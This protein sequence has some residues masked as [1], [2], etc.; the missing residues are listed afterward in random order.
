MFMSTLS[1]G[2]IRYQKGKLNITKRQKISFL[3]RWVLLTGL[4]KLKDIQIL[5]QNRSGYGLPR[6]PAP[7][8]QDCL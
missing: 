6:N 8:I 4:W 7:A 2:S 3:D 1:R 5:R